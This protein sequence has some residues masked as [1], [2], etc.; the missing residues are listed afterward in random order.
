MTAMFWTDE[1]TAA[2]I[3]MWNEGVSAAEICREIG[4]ASRCS[5]LGKVHRLKLK[6]RA[7]VRRAPR[8]VAPRR[9]Q[10]SIRT[11]AGAPA[12]DVTA[13]PAAI[14]FLSTSFGDEIDESVTAKD[15][16]ARHGPIALFDLRLRNCRW[17]IGD[18]RDVNFGFCGEN[19]DQPGSPYCAAH[20]ALAFDR[21]PRRRS[22]TS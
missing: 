16:C 13:R 8:C 19:R 7:V 10:I 15:G 12:A 11:I 9:T 21:S 14:G 1:R 6:P 3:R 5:V 22:F 4:A 2:L 17:P 20:R 18:P